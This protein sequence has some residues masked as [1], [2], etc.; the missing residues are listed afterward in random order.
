MTPPIPSLETVA[1]LEQSLLR[2]EIRR[3][4][5]AVATLLADDFVEFGSSG[6]VYDKTQII[7]ALQDETGEASYTVRDLRLKALA[8]GLGLVTYRVSHRAPATA[9]AVQSM[10][11]SIWR[12]EAG[13]WQLV[14]HQGT[15]TES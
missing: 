10:R 12:F 3:S 2:P 4:P 5:A 6:R 7:Q 9:E 14:F 11:S 13:R 8:P 15:K 1:D